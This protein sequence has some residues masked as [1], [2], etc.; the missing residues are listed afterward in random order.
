MANGRSVHRN[1]GCPVP[2]APVPQKTE[3]LEP[4]KCTA[5]SR[6]VE[7]LIGSQLD[8]N[9]FLRRA[10]SHLAR[11]K[12]GKFTLPRRL[13]NLQALFSGLT[14]SEFRNR[15]YAVKPHRSFEIALDK[16][17]FEYTKQVSPGLLWNPPLKF[18]KEE[19]DVAERF[20]LRRTDWPRSSRPIWPSTPTFAEML[21]ASRT[22][23]SFSG[24]QRSSFTPKRCIEPVH[25]DD[26]RVATRVVSDNIIGVRSR[27]LSVPR[28]FL[29]W[30]RYRAGFLILT[31]R[32]KI[33]AGLVRF[34]L[35]QW[36]TNPSSL[37]LKRKCFLKYYLRSTELSAVTP[38]PAVHK[39]ETLMPCGGEERNNS[40]RVDPPSWTEEQLLAFFESVK[41]RLENPA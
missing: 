4:R 36:K 5:L 15:M 18:S 30:F 33:P 3:I 9:L 13:S 6:E 24:F 12:P 16:R 17:T 38:T 39:A 10:R 41:H 35:A 19:A 11:P 27:P 2:L 8:R 37:W 21:V 32:Y 14:K 22:G 31:C 40:I 23:H 7:C 29:P 26:I 34:L 25:M 28:K 20:R 1:Q